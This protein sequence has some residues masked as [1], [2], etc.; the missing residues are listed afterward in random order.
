MA[1]NECEGHAGFRIDQIQASAVLT[2]P[3]RPNVVLLHGGTNDVCFYNM[4]AG[5]VSRLGGLLD[6]IFGDC[7]D[8]TVVVAQLVP[9]GL[10]ATWDGLVQT[11]NAALAQLVTGRIA[12]GQHLVL[13]DMHSVINPVTDLSDEVHPNDAGYQIMAEQWYQGINQAAVQGWIGDPVYVNPATFV[14]TERRERCYTSTKWDSLGTIASGL[15]QHTYPGVTC[16][17]K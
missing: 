12:Q 7:P 11:Y 14:A 2:L 3:E 15:G 16:T 1:N 8:A 4:S 10:N 5:A 9:S 6:V 17:A 13:V